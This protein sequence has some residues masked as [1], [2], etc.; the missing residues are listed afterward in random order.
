MFKWI[1]DRWS[2][3]EPKESESNRYSPL[4]KHYVF[5]ETGNIMLC[6]T[7]ESIRSMDEVIKDSFV[8][9]SI[10]F[11]AMTKAVHGTTNPAT[12]KPYSIYNYQAIKNILR[13]SGL[14][15]ETNVEEGYFSHTGVGH[16][17]GKSFVETVLN[18]QFDGKTLNFSK[19]M[20]NGMGYQQKGAAEAGTD[21]FKMNLCR[22]GT[23]FFV[24]ELLLGLPQT[25]AVLVNIE[26]DSRRIEDDHFDEDK[27]DIFDLGL[28]NEKTHISK[29]I[30]RSWKYKKRTYLFVPPKFL[31]NNLGS[32][33]QAN[34]EEFEEFVEGLAARL[35]HK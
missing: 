2:K 3:E 7:A 26:P 5:N 6:A 8:D 25:S 31:K 22:S 35:D 15:I 13:G 1:L 16:Q 29:G 14:F 27:Q 12:G 21:S 32:I 19:A 11:S 18:R 10:F 33:S 30:T 17:L 9:V 28:R 4:V 34:S 20:L 24:N 23:I